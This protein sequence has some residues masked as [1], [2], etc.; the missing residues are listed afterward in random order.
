[1]NLTNC[2]PKSVVSRC[3]IPWG[4]T[5]PARSA[6]SAASATRAT[7]CWP[8]LL[9]GG[10]VSTRARLAARRAGSESLIGGLVTWL[11]GRSGQP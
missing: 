8:A 3:I 9:P 4:D 7:I 10:V 11:P 2:L 5:I 1:M 6:A